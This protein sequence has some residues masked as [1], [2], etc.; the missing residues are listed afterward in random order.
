MLGDSQGELVPPSF[1]L[2]GAA[3][4]GLPPVRSLSRSEAAHGPSPTRGRVCAVVTGGQP[5]GTRAIVVI[6]AS[7]SLTEGVLGRLPPERPLHIGLFERS[8][9][10]VP[11]SASPEK[12]GASRLSRA[13][14]EL[15]DSADGPG[16]RAQRRHPKRFDIAGA[17]EFLGLSERFVRRLVQERR[18][19]HLKIGSR[20]LFDERDLDAF[21]RAA[22]R[23]AVRGI[24]SGTSDRAAALRAKPL[25]GPFH[26]DRSGQT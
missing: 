9:Q 26:R 16:N 20:V 4:P 10:A 15:L 23:E 11:K 21:M 8:A 25:T 3:Y 12:S 2:A 13:Q 24:R 1:P 5:E 7:A 22:R 14:P 6:L 17:A 18:V 19:T